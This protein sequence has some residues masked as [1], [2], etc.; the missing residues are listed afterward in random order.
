ML[1]CGGFP[2][3]ESRFYL[4][5]TVHLWVT[6]SHVP[7]QQSSFVVHAA[8]IGSH[9]TWL[10]AHDPPTH[11]PSQQSASAVHAPFNGTHVD[12]HTS[13][14]LPSGRHSLPQHSSAKLHDC[15]SATQFVFVPGP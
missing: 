14:P 11:T 3:R 2:P 10:G 5:M 4:M 13:P 9:S 15:P 12:E 8:P 6:G 1:P 7:E